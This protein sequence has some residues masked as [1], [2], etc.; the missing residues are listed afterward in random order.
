[1]LFVF[2]W[3]TGFVAAKYSMPDAEP[4]SFLAL[5][6]MLVAVVFVPLIYLTGHR[7]R[8]NLWAYR[9]DVVVGILLHACYLGTYFWAIR[10]GADAGASAIIVGIQPILTTVFAVYFLGETYTKYK[11][12]GLIGGFCGVCLVIA[13]QF[14]FNSTSQTND[15][16][17]WLTVLPIISLLSVSSALIYQKRY[18]RQ[19]NLLTQTWV[20][21]ISAALICALVAWLLGESGQTNWSPS[22]SIALAWQVC[23]ISVGAV[24]L[25]MRM[26]NQGEAGQ[27]ASLFYLVP[28]LVVLEAYFLFDEQLSN[29]A[30]VGMALSVI[31]VYLTRQR[32]S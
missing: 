5:R 7:L 21:Y 6:F 17:V 19:I 22:F 2:L 28:P 25:L 4:F 20:Q 1:M 11:S 3:S 14:G 30:F 9:H 24:L 12:L 8:L 29:W 18:C 13:A 32:A 27:V 16:S 15:T 10:L 23:G 31:G 26:V